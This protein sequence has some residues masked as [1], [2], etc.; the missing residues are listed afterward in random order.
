MD[1]IPAPP[2]TDPV[3]DPDGAVEHLIGLLPAEMHDASCWWQFTSSQSLPRDDGTL[4][5]EYLSARLW[6]WSTV[7]LSDADLKR[8]AAHHNQ[9]GRVIDTSSTRRSRRI[10][11]ARRS[12]RT[13]W[14]TRC[15]G[16]TACGAGSRTR[17][18]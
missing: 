18:R 14:R 5:N 7:P 1:H 17:S 9:R 10:T 3:G 2:L 4:D 12:S 15:R 13:A 16:A 8:W 6:F 11:P